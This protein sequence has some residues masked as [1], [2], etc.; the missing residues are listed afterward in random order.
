MAEDCKYG[1][2]GIPI[3]ETPECRARRL[4]ARRDGDAWYK[5]NDDNVEMRQSR[6]LAE[7][8]LTG[9]TAGQRSS[10]QAALILQALAPTLGAV[11]AGITAA[12]G[13]PMGLGGILGGVLAP[14][15]P[16][17]GLEQYLIPGALVL[18]AAAVAYAAARS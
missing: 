12:A 1:W 10:E 2:F 15:A 17:P 8:A 6:K 13:A 11:G 3:R 7:T 9:Q 14:A 18:G 4:A 5:K 16:A